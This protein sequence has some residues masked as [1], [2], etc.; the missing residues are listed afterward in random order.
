MLRTNVNNF[1]EKNK[2]N[3]DLKTE[4]KGDDIGKEIKNNAIRIISI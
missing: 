3:V 1:S 2:A 4:T